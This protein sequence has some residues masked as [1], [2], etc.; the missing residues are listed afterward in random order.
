MSEK[1]IPDIEETYDSISG[2]FSRRRRE[3]WPPMVA[4]LEEA[5]RPCRLLDIGCG[6]G[7]ALKAAIE[8]GCDSVGI[9]LSANQL[10]EARML[11]GDD[12]QLVQADMRRIPFPDRSFDRIMMIAALHHLPDRGARVEALREAKRLLVDGGRSLISVW[13][14]DQDRFRDRHLSRINGERSVDG[15]DGPLPGDFL[16]PWKDGVHAMR[17][18]HLYGPD[19]LRSEAKE[20]G[21]IVQRSYFDGKNHWIELLL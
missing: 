20:A 14:W 13:S 10:Q 9:D 8:H 15:S 16:V 21:W 11:V 17:F 6:A 2:S 4:F 12:V 5:G 7:R 3:L 19:E 1:G 18:F